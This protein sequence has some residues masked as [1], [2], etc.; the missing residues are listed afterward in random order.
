M[1]YNYFVSFFEA[2]GDFKVARNYRNAERAL[3]CKV[4]DTL[5]VEISD[6]PKEILQT[7]TDKKLWKMNSAAIEELMKKKYSKALE[8]TYEIAKMDTELVWPYTSIAHFL[9]L[10]GKYEKAKDIYLKY[11]GRKMLNGRLYFEDMVLDDFDDLKSLKL[12]DPGFDKIKEL[13]KELN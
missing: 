13:Y 7:E 10:D 12:Y 2:D 9:V 8:I 5:Y 3:D 4:G 11:K 1:P 6:M